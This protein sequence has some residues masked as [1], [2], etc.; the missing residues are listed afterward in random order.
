M[1][2]VRS[3]LP[4]LHPFCP[5]NHLT[6]Y[7]RIVYVPVHSPKDKYIVEVMDYQHT[8]KDRSLGITDLSVAELL[9]EG[10]DKKL[11]PW[12]STGNKAHKEPLKIDGKK[13]IKGP[14]VLPL[15]HGPRLMRMFRASRFARV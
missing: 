1:G 10:T 4:H 6:P 9:T 3:P 7:F 8:T 13:A 2:R 15:P 12:L 14:F 5:S 11:K